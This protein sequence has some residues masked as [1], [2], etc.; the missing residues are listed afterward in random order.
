MPKAQH[1]K[2]YFNK[3]LERLDDFSVALT[4]SSGEYRSWVFDDE[5]GIKVDV[6]DPLEEHA[7]MLTQYTDADMHNILAYL[8]TLK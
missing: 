1:H 5:K 7:Q 2:A 8:E 3:F 4:D 6:H